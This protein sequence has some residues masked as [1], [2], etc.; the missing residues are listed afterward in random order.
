M[1]AK[2]QM[3]TETGHGRTRSRV[4]VQLKRAL[5]STRIGFCGRRG[6]TRCILPASRLR[7]SQKTLSACESS[8]VPEGRFLKGEGPVGVS[9]RYMESETFVVTSSVTVSRSASPTRLTSRK[10]G[11]IC[12]RS[13]SAITSPDSV[14]TTRPF[15]VVPLELLKL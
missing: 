12:T 15:K 14:A 3:K 7:F 6:E 11:P 10:K 5:P 2:P 9:T 13:P 1:T 8:D 4:G